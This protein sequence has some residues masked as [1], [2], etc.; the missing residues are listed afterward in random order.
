MKKLVA[1]E[2]TIAENNDND[3]LMPTPVPSKRQKKRQKHAQLVVRSKDKEVEKT[4]AYLTKWDINR[5][6]WKYEKLRQIYIQKNIFDDGTIPEEH[7][8]AA[9]RYLATSKVST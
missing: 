6:E 4:I 1:E 7:S 2:E 8:D 3:N 9:I 5:T